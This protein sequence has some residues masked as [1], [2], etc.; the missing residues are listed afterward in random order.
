ME[1]K[2]S[3][4]IL[5]Y[6]YKIR[7]SY[8]LEGRIQCIAELL[9]NKHVILLTKRIDG[10]NCEPYLTLKNQ[11]DLQDFVKKHFKGLNFSEYYLY[12]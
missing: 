3:Y 9:Q 7:E 1:I 4:T 2:L 11:H 8:I 10:R 5:E 6:L 12:T